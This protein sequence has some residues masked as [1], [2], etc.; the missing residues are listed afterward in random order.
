[1]ISLK[2][3]LFL[4]LACSVVTFWSCEDDEADNTKP[5]VSLSSPSEGDLFNAGGT[6]ALDGTITDDVK[7]SDWKV[8]IE[9]AFSDLPMEGLFYTYED[10]SASGTAYAAER[11]IPI[12]ETV[13]AGPHILKMFSVDDAV[14]ISDTTVV[15]FMIQN[16][17]DSEKPV[18]TLTA[19]PDPTLPTSADAG[20]DNDVYVLGSVTDNLGLARMIVGWEYAADSTAYTNER[21]P[22]TVELGETSFN[23]VGNADNNSYFIAPT[24]L[25]EFNLLLTVYDA[26]NNVSEA[27]VRVNVNK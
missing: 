16:P 10:N 23:L 25:G 20:G 15:N 18:I 14:N 11:N 17:E 1:M 2:R 26:Y 9:P 6:I 27:R 8:T 7:L 13:G 24:E 12:A 3:I 5:S 4:M 19:P 22:Y 21:Y